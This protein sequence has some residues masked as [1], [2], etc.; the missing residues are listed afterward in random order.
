MAS[1]PGYRFI[2]DKMKKPESLIPIPSMEMKKTQPIITEAPEIIIE[3]DSFES[4]RAEEIAEQMIPIPKPPRHF[5]TNKG[6]LIQAI[7]I[8]DL[9]DI[10][11]IKA[12]LGMDESEFHKNFYALL[13]TGELEGRRDGF[14]AR[15]DIKDE[16]I[17]Y[18][19]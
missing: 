1:I 17:R 14:I 18:F 10:D 15:Q 6:Y 11:E 5:S 12:H 16:W 4:E 13:I 9:H 2:H 3:A 19:Q 7:V 8:D